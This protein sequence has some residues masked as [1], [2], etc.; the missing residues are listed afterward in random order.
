MRIQNPQIGRSPQERK[1]N[2]WKRFFRIFTAEFASLSILEVLVIALIV[3]GGIYYLKGVVQK[4]YEERLAEKIASLEKCQQDSQKQAETN[5][6]DRVRISDTTNVLLALQDYNFSKD[7][8]P[9]NL[10][11]LKTGG[12]LDG[13]IVDP[14]TG[15]PYYYG[16]LSPADYVLCVYL[17]SGVWGTNTG[18]CPS[19]ADYA[20][21]GEATAAN[22]PP[23]SA[24]TT[25]AV[26][27]IVISSTPT[28]TL[29]VRAAPSLTAAIITKAAPGE[30][31]EVIAEQADWTEIKLNKTVESNQTEYSSGWVSSQ[32]VKTE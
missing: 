20:S 2:F 10:A 9:A 14:E 11:D 32:Y 4:S 29:N 13:N 15:K 22:N 26:K 6:Y 12:Y 16:K 8:L 5:A 3:G 25:A 18:Q 21:S 28:G 1:M 19:Q 30:E 31:Y 27:K 24:T 7:D 23:A 17:S